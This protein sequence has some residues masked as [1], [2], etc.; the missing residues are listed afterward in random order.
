M[1]IA[2]TGD[3]WLQRFVPYLLYRITNQLTRRIRSRLRREGINISRWRVLAVLRAYGDLNLGA[4]V[5]LTVMEQPSVSRIVAQ[6]EQEGLVRRKVSREDSRFVN[7]SLTSA[8]EKAFQTVYPAA[9]KHQE[10]ALRGFSRQ[11]INTLTK[12]LR[13][14]LANI[15]AE[16]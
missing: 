7:V 1:P 3:K 12:Y 8:G 5:E 13:R 14:I 4:I 2:G 9:K 10:R 15:E 6:L 16:E 11:E